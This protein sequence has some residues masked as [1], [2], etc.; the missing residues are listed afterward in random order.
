MC[1][2][3]VPEACLPIVYVPVHIVMGMPMAITMGTKK[4][5]IGI[6]HGYSHGH[7]HYFL[8]VPMTFSMGTK[9]IHNFVNWYY[10]LRES[11]PQSRVFVFYY[12]PRRHPPPPPPPF[13]KTPNFF[14]TRSLIDYSQIVDPSERVKVAPDQKRQIVT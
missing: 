4:H 5:I 10:T 12:P 7:A 6:A 1:S 11:R 3:Y 8:A 9:E 2:G 14:L 13:G